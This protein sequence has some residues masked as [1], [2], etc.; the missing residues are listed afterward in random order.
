MPAPQRPKKSRSGSSGLP[1][2]AHSDTAA[3]VSAVLTTTR[4]EVSTD[5]VSAAP[6]P[7]SQIDAPLAE[8]AHRPDNP[9][10]AREYDP[11]ADPELAAFAATVDEFGILQ[12]VTVCSREAWLEHHPHDKFADEVR[13]VVIMGNRRLAT[14]RH[15]KVD[16]LP[17]HRNDRLADPR[18]SKES[19]IIE[20]YHRKPYDPIREGG[21]M[22]AVL[23]MTGESKRAF[24][25]R[26]GISHTQVNQRLQL[27]ELIPEFQGM[28]SDLAMPVQKAL[29]IAVLPAEHQRALLDLGQPYDPDRLITEPDSESGTDDGKSLSTTAAVKIPKSSTPDDVAKVLRDKLDPALLNAVLN[30]LT[31][32]ASLRDPHRA[33]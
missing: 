4:A 12:A 27:L 26:M 24:A 20:N 7:A 16:R 5:G 25:E 9:R 19:G 8:F 1:S 32:D 11:E 6:P 13:Y 17:L 31:G 29:K 21:E 15:K 30:I 33:R 10:W 2:T 22:A 23:A 18:L 14:A 28:V 3:I